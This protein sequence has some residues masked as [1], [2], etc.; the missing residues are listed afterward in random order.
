MPTSMFRTSEVHLTR[1]LYLKK[2][3]AL[4]INYNDDIS[5]MKRKGRA[6]SFIGSYGQHPIY[7]ATSGTF[8]V[9]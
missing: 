6:S 2:A 7:H 8:R 4:E 1:T 3:N 5:N 9:T